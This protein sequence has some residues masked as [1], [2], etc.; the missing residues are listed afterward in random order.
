MATEG[1]PKKENR[2]PDSDML[3]KEV[4]SITSKVTVIIIM[5]ELKTVKSNPK[6]RIPEE[7]ECRVICIFGF[8]SCHAFYVGMTSWHLKP[9]MVEHQKDNTPVKQNFSEW[10][11]EVVSKSILT[12][13]NL[14]KITIL[15]ALF[16]E[17]LK[18]SKKSKKNRQTIPDRAI[19]LMKLL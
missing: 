16:T 17:K 11:V 3:L 9:R 13:F 7:L 8:S 10:T 2:R 18:L 12:F 6:A 5:E 19:V 1:M 15:V 4:R 14:T